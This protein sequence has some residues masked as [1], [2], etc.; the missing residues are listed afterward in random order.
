[1][2]K[3]SF[4]KLSAFAFVA[5]VAAMLTVASCN[6]EEQTVT[7]AP[8]GNEFLTTTI[9]TC[10]NS[11]APFDTVIG[12]WRDLT[13]EDT[14]PPDTSQAILN[15]KKNSVYNVSIGLLDETTNPAGDIGADVLSRGNYHLFCFNTSS[16]L[17]NNF[18]ITRTDH[19]TNNPPLAIGLKNNFTTINTSIGTLEV[20]LRH[21]PNVKN[22]SCD[23]GSTDLD[24]NFQVNV[25][26]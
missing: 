23:P 13:P 18:S 9:L 24:V 6:K 3:K 12:T 19:D 10:I 22:G 8:P 4:F 14:L 26:N 15:L 20:I 21:Q 11:S 17:G 7:P 1:M 5:I 2:Y 16:S 25:I